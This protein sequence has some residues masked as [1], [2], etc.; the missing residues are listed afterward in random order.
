[1]A[2]TWSSAVIGL[3][4][5]IVSGTA[6]PF[7]ISGGTSIFTLPLL[8]GASPTTF[9]IAACIDAGVA[10]AGFTASGSTIPTA[11]ASAAVSIRSGAGLLAACHRRASW[12]SLVRQGR[13]VGDH[14]PDRLRGQ[15]RLA[16]KGRSHA[17]E[18]V[19]P[20]IGR[21][22]R[23]RVEV[24]C[25]HDPQPQLAL[26]PARSGS[27]EV[28]RQC[29]LE[30]LLREGPAVAEEAEAH[31]PVNDDIAPAFHV[32]LRTSQRLGDGISNHGIGTQL[33]LA[34]RVTGE[35]CDRG[36]ERSCTDERAATLS[37]R[38]RW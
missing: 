22:D 25:I 23:V 4:Q 2:L 36:G 13:E 29:A 20:V 18:T 3:S 8:T 1:M 31:L 37:R 32:P 9:L 27:L 21:H 7:S 15:H 35:A 10:D 5:E 11:P 16:L 30:L 17:R 38:L 14:V 33:L 26:R 6:L 19:D 24:A 28:R 12:C 34:P